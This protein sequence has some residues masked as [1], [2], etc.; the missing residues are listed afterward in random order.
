MDGSSTADSKNN[1]GI[2]RIRTGD[3]KVQFLARA[4]L[5]LAQNDLAIIFRRVAAHLTQFAAA[6]LYLQLVAA[7]RA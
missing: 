6:S 3:L 2:G 5:L 4:L 7:P 1:D